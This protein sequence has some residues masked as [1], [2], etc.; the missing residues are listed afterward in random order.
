VLNRIRSRAG[1]PRQ[2]R[3]GSATGPP[4][5]VGAGAQRSGTEWWYGLIVDHPQ[6]VPAGG[7]ELHFFDRYLDEDFTE[8]DIAAYHRHCPAGD[9]LVSGEWT[10]RYMYDF[11]TPRLLARSAPQARILVLLRDPWERYLSGLGH[12]SRAL[13]QE[14]RRRERQRR[15]D[16]RYVRTLIANDALNRSLYTR[17][18]ERL[19]ES[20][21]RAQLLIL[22][23]E[24]CA[25]DPEGELRR[26]YEFLGLDPADHKPAGLTE[27]AGRSST[28]PSIPTHVAA[29]AKRL[30]AADAAR[31]GA[32]VPGLDLGVWPTCNDR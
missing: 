10:P 27:R 9:G 13:A 7:K 8:E 23:Y 4:H 30:M 18:V 2:E 5:F 1:R 6:V 29:S 12:E 22:Q 26:T 28:K 14:L 11:W 16:P 32:L 25:A 3:V 24:R 31:L 21:D 19:L 20:F 17:Q 15:K